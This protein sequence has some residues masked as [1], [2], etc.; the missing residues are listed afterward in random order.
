LE[1]AEEVLGEVVQNPEWLVKEG[2]EK[3]TVLSKTIQVTLSALK[4]APAGRL[5]AETSK[6]V[7]KTVLKSVALRKELLKKIRVDKEEKE[8]I[9]VILD[10]LTNALLSSKVD[11]NVRWVLGRNEIFSQ[12][13]CLALQKLAEN[14]PS[15][16]AIVKLR[17]ILGQA[18]ENIKAAGPWRLESILDD[19]AKVAA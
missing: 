17:K 19:I 13:A 14:G 8:T 12:I 3:S 10:V 5:N 1:I 11:R 4:R 7:I 6:K 15:E 18:A 16:E 2:G 9:G